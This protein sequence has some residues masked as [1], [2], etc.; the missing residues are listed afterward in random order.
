MFKPISAI[1]APQ[2]H[3]PGTVSGCYFYHTFVKSQKYPTLC[4]IRKIGDRW[5][6]A[7]Q[8]RHNRRMSQLQSKSKACWKKST[9]LDSLRWDNLP[10]GYLLRFYWPFETHFRANKWL[11]LRSILVNLVQFGFWPF[12]L[13]DLGKH[14]LFWPSPTL[15]D[16]G[17]LPVLISCLG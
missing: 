16:L 3:I 6:F 14:P 13:L 11:P 9:S 17:D 2:T 15:P 1:S 4:R 12:S 7:V 8:Y 5:R 10:L